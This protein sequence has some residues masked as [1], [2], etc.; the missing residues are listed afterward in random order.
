MT[1]NWR[2]RC[3][4]SAL[5]VA[6]L[7]S[8]AAAAHGQ[9]TTT[10]PA[11]DRGLTDRPVEVYSI[12]RAEDRSWEMFSSIRGV[13]FDA[14][15]NLYAL[16]AGNHRVLV[17]DGSGRFVREFGRRGSGPGELQGPATSS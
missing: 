10:L 15:D 17:F 11:R 3:I 8:L 2:I 7:V 13:A 6:V 1:C 9:Q 16:D 5:P 14:S 4:G 12:G